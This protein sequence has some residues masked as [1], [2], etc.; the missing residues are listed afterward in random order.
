MRIVDC[1]LSWTGQSLQEYS[2]V[3]GLVVM[4]SV[5]ALAICKDQ[6]SGM[7]TN[8]LSSGQAPLVANAGPTSGTNPALQ[9]PLNTTG[10]PITILFGNGQS[11][12]LQMPNQ[13]NLMETVGPNGVTEGN[14]AALQQM[15]DTLKSQP[16]TDPGVFQALEAMANTGHLI[17]QQQAAM[18]E[19]Y[20]KV[21][22]DPGF[23]NNAHM[24]MVTENPSSFTGMLQD[25]NSDMKYAVITP[26]PTTY[27]PSGPSSCTQDYQL[28]NYMGTSKKLS[29]LSLS[30]QLGAY[31][32]ISELAMEANNMGALVP[33]MQELRLNITESLNQSNQAVLTAANGDYVAELE[34]WIKTHENSNDICTLSDGGNCQQSTAN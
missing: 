11:M 26:L 32:R 29:E 21:R 25:A 31:Q 30:D 34:P 2:L 9:N 16:G 23:P 12:T 15:I 6:L 24:L 5:G 33:V 1:R 14:L 27:C 19:S 22:M 17:A 18:D 3:I 7:L 13:Q 10:N 4:A 28:D 20:R 8:T